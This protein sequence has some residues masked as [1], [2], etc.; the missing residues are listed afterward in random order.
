MCLC[1]QAQKELLD[2]ELDFHKRMSTG[3]DTTDLKRKLGQLQ[4]EVMNA[5]TQFKMPLSL[6]RLS[7]SGITHTS[8]QLRFGLSTARLLLI[9]MQTKISQMEPLLA[10]P[11]LAPL[12]LLFPL[13]TKLAFF[14]KNA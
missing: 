2:A 12:F 4:V 11:L 6:C 1:V 14:F 13:A 3:E 10:T 7:V 5:H 8:L 9:Q